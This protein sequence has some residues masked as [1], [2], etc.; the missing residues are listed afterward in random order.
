MTIN[1]SDVI[2]FNSQRL[3]QTQHCVK[4]RQQLATYL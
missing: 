3:L 4:V 2:Q 1:F